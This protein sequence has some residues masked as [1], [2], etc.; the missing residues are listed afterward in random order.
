MR[1]R[2]DPRYSLLTLVYVA[3]IHWLS[4]VPDLSASESDPLTL[5]FMNLGHAPL[6]AGLAFCV[7]KSLSRVGE[8]H[9]NRYALA[10]AVSTACAALDEWFQSFVAGRHSSIGDLLVD[11]AGIGAMLV[12]LALRN[13]GTERPQGSS[14]ME[15]SGSKGVRGSRI[16]LSRDLTPFFRKLID[17]DSCHWTDRT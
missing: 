2:L 14:E 1:I 17:K 6:F 11:V 16:T 7:L 9:G 4:S 8:A 13:R 10:L 5:L 15:S 3:T 12:F